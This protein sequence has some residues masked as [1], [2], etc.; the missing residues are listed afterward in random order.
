MTE[1]TYQAFDSLSPANLFPIDS[2]NAS[3]SM[4]ESD[5]AVNGFIEMLYR[6]DFT[7][8]SNA[9]FDTHYPE[10]LSLEILGFSL[11]PC[12]VVRM[13]E[14]PQ[15]NRKNILLRGDDFWL[16]LE[17]F[18]SRTNARC[19]ANSLERVH[20]V[21]ERL[22][23]GVERKAP[24]E[25]KVH[26]EMCAYNTMQS[27]KSF[28]DVEWNSVKDNYA[29]RTQK[30]IEALTTM[31][32]PVL[33]N[34]DGRIILFHGSP[35][36]GKTWA[37]RSLLTHWKPWSD[38]ILILDPERLFSDF[39]Y[40]LEVLSN[41]GRG[42]TRVF[43]IEDADGIVEKNGI[44]SADLSRLLNMADGLLGASYKVLFL[45][46]TNAKVHDLDQALVRPG[47]CRAMVDF[48]AFSTAEAT[49]RLGEFGPAAGP[50][51]LAEIYRITKKTDSVSDTSSSS[52][53]G[54]YL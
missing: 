23:A 12:T 34:N 46:T 29:S 44:R 33:G 35:G 36:T 51:T 50:M 41:T 38:P 1:L 42:K 22:K 37:I 3:R 48:E 52:L 43:I 32:E 49:A 47:R 2:G 16:A 25:S 39:S 14:S 45:L 30:Q 19:G 4:N 27:S 20:E 28:E 11:P 8:A 10:G 7:F 17:V 5:I 18:A 15:Y 21:L 53:I 40:F 13:V 24:S 54:Q 6:G 9:Y 26:Y 31:T